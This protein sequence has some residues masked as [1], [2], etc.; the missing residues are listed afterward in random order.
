MEIL[1]AVLACCRCVLA[2]IAA[3]ALVRRL[4]RRWRGG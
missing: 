2:A 4:R 3:G 1:V